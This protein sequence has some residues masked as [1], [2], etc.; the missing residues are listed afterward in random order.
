VLGQAGDAIA[1]ADAERAQTLRCA[2]RGLLELR[3]APDP[4]RRPVG[5]RI[6]SISVFMKPLRDCVRRE[7]TVTGSDAFRIR[8]YATAR[9]LDR[10]ELSE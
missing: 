9:A 6:A 3:E 4:R 2:V 8:S 5:Q 10:L 7:P 1:L